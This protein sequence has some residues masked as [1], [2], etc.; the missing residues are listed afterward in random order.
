M[1]VIFAQIF[2][3]TFLI[4]GLSI[5]LDRKSTSIAINKISEN[6]GLMWTLGF[7]SVLLGATIFP[8]INPMRDT[9]SLVLYIFSIIAIFKGIFL[10]WMPGHVSKFYEKIMKNHNMILISGTLCIILSIYFLIASF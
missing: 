10:L 5:V 3:L 9:L 8:F 7:F 2:G 1:P 6:S 4:T